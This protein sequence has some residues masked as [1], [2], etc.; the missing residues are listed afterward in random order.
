M[1]NMFMPQRANIRINY[2]KE[3]NKGQAKDYVYS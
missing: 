3:V 2:I 1:I